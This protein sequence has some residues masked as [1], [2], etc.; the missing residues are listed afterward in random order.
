M[1]SSNH[2]LGVDAALADFGLVKS[3]GA[4]DDIKQILIGDPT[5]YLRELRRGKLFTRGGAIAQAAN[6]HVPGSPGMTALNATLNYGLPLY[7]LYQTAHAPA[8]E[9]GSALGSSIG[10][11]L[12]GL[13]GAPLGLAG[14][15]AGG[16]LGAS[17]GEH[18]GRLFNRTSSSAPPRPHPSREPPADRRI[19]PQFAPRPAV[20]PLSSTMSQVTRRP[21]EFGG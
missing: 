20:S 2:A 12:G 15:M 10:A 9:R 17:L 14:N 19:L 1:S 7:G 21:T 18:V 11:L 16:T 8:S 6:P 5:R 3:A 4:G 13:V